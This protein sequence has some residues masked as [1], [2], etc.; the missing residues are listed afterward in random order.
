MSANN[1]I[2]IFKQDM[3]WQVEERDAETDGLIEDLGGWADLESAIH[4]ANDFMSREEVEYG[5]DIKL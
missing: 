2:T 3:E 5:L 4:C 1:K